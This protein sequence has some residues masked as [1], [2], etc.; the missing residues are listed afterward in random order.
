MPLDHHG[1][2]RRQRGSRVAAGHAER[3][4]EVGGAEHGDRADGAHHAPQVGL[5]DGCAVRH[6]RVD[7]GLHP[8]AAR[9]DIGKGAQ[10]PGGA[11]TLSRQANRA[12]GRFRVAD[13]DQRI[14]HGLDLA[15]QRVQQRSD[16]SAIKLLY[17][18]V[19]L[20]CRSQGHQA[21]VYSLITIVSP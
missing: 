6:G 8:L 21:C 10:L 11:A 18:L 4:R 9:C 19:G 17:A 12:Q 14:A 15:G 5:G 20:T 13:L 2:A 16:R 3:Q 7:A 1:V